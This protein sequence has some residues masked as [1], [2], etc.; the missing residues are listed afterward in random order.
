MSNAEKNK[1]IKSREDFIAFVRT[2]S[3]DFRENPQSWENDNL[4]RFLE[5]LGSWVE[6][7]DGYYRNQGKPVPQQLDWNTLA[8]MLM[9]AK[10]YE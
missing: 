8:D 2:L 3:K 4:E 10:M 5:A 1:S 9:A 7:M 6:D